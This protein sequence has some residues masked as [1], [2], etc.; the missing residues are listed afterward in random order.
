MILRRSNSYY[1][2]WNRN[3]I[4]KDIGYRQITKFISLKYGINRAKEDLRKTLLILDPV[5]IE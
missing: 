2:Q 1:L 5:E 4:S 3:V